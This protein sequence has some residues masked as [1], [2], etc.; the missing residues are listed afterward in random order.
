MLV[1]PCRAVHNDAGSQHYGYGDKYGD[2]IFFG[3]IASPQ[4]HGD[5]DSYPVL[6][7]G[8]SDLGPGLGKK[9]PCH[10]EELL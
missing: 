6:G 2:G 10:N 4:L 3:K 7:G 8:R 1:F 5:K 9:I